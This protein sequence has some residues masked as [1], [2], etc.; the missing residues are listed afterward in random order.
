MLNVLQTLVLVA[1]P[2]LVIIAAL[3]DVTSYRIPNWISLAL[4]GAFA[5]AALVISPP[6]PVLGLNLAVGFAG[7]ILGM[8]MF[9]LGWIGG[10]DAKLFA[11]AALWL[12]WPAIPQFLL[13]T[14]LGGGALAVF[15]V[16][17]RSDWVRAMVPAGPAWIERL[18]EPKGPAPYGVA[19][20]LGGLAAFPASS[21]VAALSGG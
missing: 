5:V 2:A 19:I 1:F 15:L 4:T 7:L 3:K 14:A 17:V 6:M 13:I 21:L 9:A 8:G 18:R 10:G 16:S 12:G 20:A 11:A